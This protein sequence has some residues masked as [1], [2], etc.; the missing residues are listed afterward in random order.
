MVPAQDLRQNLVPID[1]SSI[2][3]LRRVEE[4]SGR[5]RV[6]FT[7]QSKDFSPR[8]VTG[9]LIFARTRDVT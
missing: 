6:P 4:G 5:S 9:A 2:A 7:I 1:R 3:M 8:A